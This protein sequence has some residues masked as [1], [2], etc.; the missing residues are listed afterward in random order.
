M[1]KPLPTLVQRSLLAATLLALAGCSPVA[2]PGKPAAPAERI[3]P[4]APVAP[5]AARAA[6]AG[7]AVASAAIAPAPA[8]AAGPR[9]RAD[10]PLRAGMARV[11][12]LT[13]AFAHAEHGHLDRAQELALAE[14]LDAT[15]N[16]IFAEC[17]LEPAPDAAL[18]PLLAR[19]LAVGTAVRA[20]P[21]DAATVAELRAVLARYAQLFDDA[22]A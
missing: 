22:T 3:A 19:L 7:P 15:V 18:H 16:T 17:R 11:R 1:P 8:L 9:W 6:P 20:R 12:T 5:V 14:Q 2:A 10:P 4:V 13:D 21:A